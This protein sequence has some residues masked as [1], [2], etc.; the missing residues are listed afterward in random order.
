MALPHLILA[1]SVSPTCLLLAAGP[2]DRPMQVVFLS[3]GFLPLQLSKEVSLSSVLWPGTSFLIK[4]KLRYSQ[5]LFFSVMQVL[6][7]SSV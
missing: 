5:S 1:H 7:I 6:K 2:F 4:L 3:S